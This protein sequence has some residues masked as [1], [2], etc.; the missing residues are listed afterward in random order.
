MNIKK[1]IINTQYYC[2][3]IAILL[4]DIIVVFRIKNILI[5]IN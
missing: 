3:I 1:Y 2:N 4:L 5:Y